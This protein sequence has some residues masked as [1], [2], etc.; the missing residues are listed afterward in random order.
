[1]AHSVARLSHTVRWHARSRTNAYTSM[2]RGGWILGNSRMQQLIEISLWFWSAH[3]DFSKP[4]QDV[5]TEYSRKVNFLK[6]LIKTEKMASS[7]VNFPN[8]NLFS[9]IALSSQKV[10]TSKIF[11]FVHWIQ[12]S[13]SEKAMAAELLTPAPL[14]S[15]SSAPSR[16]LHIQTKARYQKE[17]RDELLGNSDDTS[18]SHYIFL[19]F[20]LPPANEVSGKIMFSKA[21]VIL[22]TG[23]GGWSASRG[24]G[25]HQGRGGSVSR[26]CVSGWGGGL[27][28]RILLECILV[29]F[30]IY[31]TVVVLSVFE[32]IFVFLWG[33]VYRY[34]FQLSGFYSSVQIWCCL[35]GW[36]YPLAGL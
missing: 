28:R 19:L 32:L 17:V 36:N 2:W 27:S 24:K 8:Y 21:S 15:E 33:F 30:F 34:I 18:R 13:A 10:A 6:G 16:E 22:S 3:F 25:L 5:L 1:M 11:I 23:G 4:R 7:H 9:G 14:S 12:E 20:L 26:G 35:S 31:F 29:F